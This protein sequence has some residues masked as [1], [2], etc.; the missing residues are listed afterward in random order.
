M[1]IRRET[2]EDAV[3]IT[4]VNDA[5]FGQKVEGELVARLRERGALVLSLVAIEDDRIVGH[6]AFSPVEVETSHS[7]FKAIALG[8]MSVLPAYQRRGIGSKL[9]RAG[10]EEI[11]KLGHEMVFLVGHQDYYPRF[12]FVPAKPKNFVC[13]FAVPNEAWMVLE[14]REGVLEGRWGLVRFQPEFREAG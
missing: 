9:V 8:P 6:I 4:N 5:A 3:A 10:I 12:G 14:L 13:E 11:R 7:R 1:I 2:P